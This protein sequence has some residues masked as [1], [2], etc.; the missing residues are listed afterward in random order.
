MS[1]S[2]SVFSVPADLADMM[3]RI[4]LK[5]ELGNEVELGL[6]QI[7]VVLLISHH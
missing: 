5:T 7:D 4:E 1:P 6:E 3:L 2:P